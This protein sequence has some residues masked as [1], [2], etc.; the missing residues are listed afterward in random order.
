MVHWLSMKF[1]DNGWT[2][3]MVSLRVGVVSLKVA[4]VVLHRHSKG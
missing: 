3:C 1:L 2:A 4:A